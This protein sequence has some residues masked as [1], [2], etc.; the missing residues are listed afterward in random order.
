MLYQETLPKMRFWGYRLSTILKSFITLYTLPPEKVD[1]F[2]NSYVIYEH[3]WTDEKDLIE[4]LGPNYETEVQKKLIDYYSVLNHLC[5]IGQVEKMYIPP[6]I[7]LSLSIIKNQILFEEKLCNDLGIDFGNK[8]LDIGCGRGRVATHIAQM[9]GGKIIGMNIDE[10]QLE[11]AIKF[12]AGHGLS[13]YCEFIKGDVNNIPYPFPDSSFDYIYEIQC[14]FTIAKDL[15]KAFK[16]IYRL[17]KPGGKFGCLEWVSLD[18]FDSKNLH[19]AHLMKQI[20]PL[21]GAIGTHSVDECIRLLKEAG[22]KIIKN[23]NAS[24]NG[25]QAPLIENADRFFTRINRLIDVFVNCKVLPEHFKVLFDRLTKD[26]QAF[27]EADR[28]GLVT[29]SQYIISQKEN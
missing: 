7:N 17:L 8:I 11:N 23:E 21:I 12:T 22:F 1:A 15:G 19:H 9:S 13:Q 28:L 10:N 4:S 14:V 27:I 29:T 16:E 5:S 18:K 26:G 25:Y 3:D 2:L 24:I 6:A 20:K